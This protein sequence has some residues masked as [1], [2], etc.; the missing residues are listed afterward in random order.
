MIRSTTNWALASAAATIVML[1][2]AQA[3]AYD[4]VDAAREFILYSAN[5]SPTDADDNQWATPCE[6]DWSIYSGSTKGA[7]FFTLSLR[8]AHGYEGADLVGM[9]GS[10][11][12][13][14]G[15][16][17]PLKADFFSLINAS[18]VVGSSSTPSPETYFRRVTTAAQVARGDLMVIGTTDSYVGHTMMITG[19]AV[20]IA[21]Q[22]SPT[23][24]GTQQWAVSIADSTSTAHGCNSVYPDS[25]WRGSCVNGAMFS[26]AGTAT[27][28]L[29]TDLLTG[30]L[31]GYTWSVTPS[32]YYSP[33]MRPYR[34]GRLTNLP[35]PLPP[36]TDPPPPP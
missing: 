12:P 9:W 13:P 1:G 16:S 19:P 25:R 36:P 14:S 22:K 23:Y 24:W 32:S 26:G 6:I 29:Y 3:S 34:I 4:H 10:T 27:I 33:T 35:A 7:C 15:D 5:N 28:R 18:P 17:D 20:E 8:H 30:E 31:L 11:A 2:A 21:P